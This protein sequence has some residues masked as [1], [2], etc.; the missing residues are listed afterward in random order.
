MKAEL[1]YLA[2]TIL[3]E[4]IAK[5]DS[6]I[7]LAQEGITSTIT[8]G[9]RSYIQ[10]LFDPK[11]PISISSL[12]S[13][14]VGGLLWKLPGKKFAILYSLASAL[15]FD[16]KSFWEN[17]GK[18]VVDFVKEIIASGKKADPEQTASRVNSIVSQAVSSSFS[19]N[20]NK[21]KLEELAKSGDLAQSGVDQQQVNDMFSFSNINAE[22]IKTAGSKSKLAGVIIKIVG[23]LIITLLGV[24][25]VSMLGKTTIK[26]DNSKSEQVEQNAGIGKLISISPNAPQE[27][28]SLHKNNMSSIWIEHGDINNIESI[29]LSWIFSAYPQLKKYETQL[30]ESAGFNSMVD[31]FQERN[32]LANGLNMISIPRPY[33]RK[34]DIVSF[35]VGSFLRSF[36]PSNEDIKE[37]P[38]A[39]PLEPY[40]P[41]PTTK[42]KPI[43]A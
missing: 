20:V 32:R 4:S 11:K 6:L 34:I 9:L 41:K 42:T 18:E 2:D 30:K 29:L 21:T 31:K 1:Q 33:Q 13:L 23:W 38:K 8:N 26:T 19:D 3:I 25:G 36:K 7:S 12:T 35:I 27:L 15:G 16:W 43:E 28:F 5:N 10:S 40:H 24:I 14:L 17:V 22:L 37:Q 39:I